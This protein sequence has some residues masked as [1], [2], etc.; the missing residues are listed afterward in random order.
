MAHGIV[1]VYAHGGNGGVLD[2]WASGRLQED[3]GLVGSLE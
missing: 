3:T 2:D 1:H